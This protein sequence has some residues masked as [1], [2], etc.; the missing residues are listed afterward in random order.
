MD[1]L[2]VAS[3]SSAFIRLKLLNIEEP[4][5]FVSAIEEIMMS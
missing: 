4:A 3:M 5:G 2:T 1:L